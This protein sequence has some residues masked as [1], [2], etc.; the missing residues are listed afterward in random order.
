LV[1]TVLAEC[2]EGFVRRS[3]HAV[4][5][6]SAELLLDLLESVVSGLAP[7]AVVDLSRRDERDLEIAVPRGFLRGRADQQ[8]RGENGDQE[9]RQ[10]QSLVHTQT[11]FV[12]NWSAG[13][14]CA[15]R[16]RRKSNS[17]PLLDSKKKPRGVLPR[18]LQAIGQL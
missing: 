18:G 8:H 11:P 16:G 2:G 12:A 4:R 5:S 14:V 10:A 17:F 6:F 13:S 1:A 7:A 15:G 9:G 3:C